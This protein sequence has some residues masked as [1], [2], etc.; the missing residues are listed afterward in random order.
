MA[1]DELVD[2][3]RADEVAPAGGDV[4]GTA[5]G[6]DVA[7]GLGEERGAGIGGVANGVLVAPGAA[8]E[9]IVLVGEAMVDADRVVL[10]RLGH[11]RR[12]R[13]IG[14]VESVAAGEVIR[15]RQLGDR[16]GDVLVQA[17]SLRVVG[18]HVI[19]VDR[20]AGERIARRV[21]RGSGRAERA[22]AAVRDVAQ[23]AL[24]RRRGVG[25]TVDGAGLRRR[26]ALEIE[27]EECRVLA[28]GAADAAAVDV[29][30]ELA[31]SEV[32]EVVG[33]LV[34][35]EARRAVEPE[36]VAVKFVR[37]G[38]RHEHDVRAAVAADVRGGVAGDDAEFAR[39]N[40]DWCGWARSWSR[41][42]RGR[43]CR[44]RRA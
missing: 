15:E 27:K 12:P 11:G 9:Q 38:L 40:P 4:L 37:P 33:P 34:R 32:V 31:F 6:V 25:Q 36:A 26:E 24:A 21:N 44:C 14:G 29:L 30:D 2:D 39:P 18:H 16:R 8:R 5:L 23:E 35:V 20:D 19:G 10:L 17:E 41:R 22:I 42:R 43:C 13:V 28:D 1:E 7:A 3:L